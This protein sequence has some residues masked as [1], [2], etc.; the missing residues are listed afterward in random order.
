MI[1]NMF[2]QHQQLNYKTILFKPRQPSNNTKCL[3]NFT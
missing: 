1:M 3:V 2:L